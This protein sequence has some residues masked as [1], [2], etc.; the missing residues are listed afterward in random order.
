MNKARNYVL[1]TVSEMSFAFR[2]RRLIG[3][4]K[5]GTR[6]KSKILDMSHSSAGEDV[7]TGETADR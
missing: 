4:H 5:N 7:N 1:L 6:M 3:K 2:D